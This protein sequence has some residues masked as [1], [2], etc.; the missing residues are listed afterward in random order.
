[1]GGVRKTRKLLPPSTTQCNK[2]GYRGV[3]WDKLKQNFRAR[4]GSRNGHNPARYLIG[5]HSTAASAAM[6]YDDEARRIYGESARLNFPS[7]EERKL[8]VTRRSE[9]KNICSKGHDLIAYGR[10]TAAG[11]V[12]CRLCNN[13]ATQRYKARKSAKSGA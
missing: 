9:V 8:E 12:H 4:V 7:V 11:R 3:V 13:A 10:T 5:R 6:A 1:M 2:H